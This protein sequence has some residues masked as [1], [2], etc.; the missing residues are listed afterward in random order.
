MQV[1]VR[2][3]PSPTGY[4]HVGG[5]R[6][7]LFNWLFA[8][9]NNGAF[10]I[11]IE[12]TDI[13]RSEE[14]YTQSILESLYWTSIYPD[15]PILIQSERLSEHKKII[16]ELI[17]TDKAY[18]CFCTQEE[19]EKR[20]SKD[21]DSYF[22]YDEKCRDIVPRNEDLTKQFVVR[23]KIPNETEE[24]EFDDL[25]R[26]HLTF[27]RDQFDDFIILRSD[28]MPTY[29]FVVVADDAFMNITH[30]LRGEDHIS[31]TP[32]QILLYQACDYS[33]PLFGHIP[34]I[35]GPDG[36]RLSKR[37]A[38]TSVVEYKRNGFLPDALCNYLV[39][40]GWSY[41]DQEIFTKDEMIKYFTIDHVGKKGAIFDIK[42]LEWVNNFYI[43]NCTA[44]ELLQFIDKDVDSGFVK[45]VDKWKDERLL[46]AL[47]LFK[48]RINTLK[49]LIKE[50]ENLYNGPTV[51]L[52]EQKEIQPWLT[53]ET[54]N[55]LNLIEED[56]FR[57]E[58][59]SQDAISD[60]LKRR[61]KEKNWKLPFIAQP[62]RIALTGKLSSPGIYDLLFLLGKEESL[63]R[64]RNLIEFIKSGVGSINPN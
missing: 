52:F 21:D 23:F 53:E 18:R 54:A 37:H 7:A 56:L 27:K 1:R 12:D 8:R 44:Q 49:E 15:E 22:K 10:L 62:I 55:V 58:D 32:K 14:K 34:L 16:S 13:E 50:I 59:F 47:D 6:T 2:F 17:E 33:I 60:I 36:S 43:K 28:G 41:G 31:N 35:L 20:L 26:G 61:L 51:G 3:A 48:E 5:L 46:F 29:N 38:A 63:R 45:R 25:I 9:H 39:R 11:R 64:I 19:L 40:L 30:I 4:L 24:I 42:K 57:L